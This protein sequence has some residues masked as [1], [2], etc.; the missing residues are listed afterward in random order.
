MLVKYGLDLWTTPGFQYKAVTTCG[1]LKPSNGALVMGA[2]V[3]K[4]AR[5]LFPG[6]DLDWGRWH[7]KYGQRV[8]LD[9]GRGLI[10]FPTKIK[11]RDPSPL[12]RVV[13]SAVELQEIMD[14]Y[15]VESV[16]MPPPGCGLGRLNWEQ[17]V[18]PKLLDL[19]DDRVTVTLPN[20]I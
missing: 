8:F 12:E 6:V 14:K 1:V 3:A 16:L 13:Q 20:R 5:D 17:D 10:A 18:A 19:L 9:R 11:W 2:G 7:N 15:Q 4:Q